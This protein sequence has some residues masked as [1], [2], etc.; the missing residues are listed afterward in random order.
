MDAFSTSASRPGWSKA[1]QKKADSHLRRKEPA[2]TLPVLARRRSGQQ[3]ATGARSSPLHAFLAEAND[4]ESYSRSQLRAM[5][6]SKLQFTG[7]NN[8]ASSNP[9]MHSNAERL[10]PLDP[11]SFEKTR[12]P[13]R[14]LPGPLQAAIDEVLAVRDTD[15]VLSERGESRD[16]SALDEPEIPVVPSCKRA[17]P[18]KNQFRSRRPEWR[19]YIRRIMMTKGIRGSTLARY[20]RLVGIVARKNLTQSYAGAA[21]RVVRYR[22]EFRSAVTIQIMISRFLMRRRAAKQM[23]RHRAASRIQHIW[24]KV[25]EIEKQRKLA[26]MA[27][28]A[29]I[30][31]LARLGAARTM[32]RS[33]RKYRQTCRLREKQLRE[34]QQA[35]MLQ[36]ARLKLFQRY[37]SWRASSKQSTI[38]LKSLELSSL[39]NAI[40]NASDRANKSFSS[41]ESSPISS[42]AHVQVAVTCA[43][44]VGGE[45]A[46][47]DSSQTRAKTPQNEPDPAEKDSTTSKLTLKDNEE[48]SDEEESVRL[49]EHAV[50]PQQNQSPAKLECNSASIIADENQPVAESE[51][52][53]VQD[54][55]DFS[56]PGSLECEEIEKVSSE[57]VISSSQ[58]QSVPESDHESCDNNLEHEAETSVASVDHN[59]LESFVENAASLIKEE[60][61]S[62]LAAVIENTRTAT[63]KRIARFLLPKVQAKHAEKTLA[64]IQIQCFARVCLAKQY[65]T[66]VRLAALQSL[67][68]QLLAAWCPAVP[69]KTCSQEDSRDPAQDEHDD[70]DN[71]FDLETQGYHPS[72][73][74]ASNNYLHLLPTRNGQ[75]PPGVPVLQSSAGAPLLSLWK[76]SWPGERW[77]STGQ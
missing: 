40:T 18:C 28:Q 51:G 15:E 36:R 52:A 22:L 2:V 1:L 32:Q 66:Q 44:N 33:Y 72:L 6:S 7:N 3:T 34:Q 19:R 46:T 71:E 47:A 21:E 73:H 59:D 24:R 53:L 29:E 45:L 13:R 25:F 64:A 20:R 56:S 42:R 8:L 12:A 11:S 61:A 30:E 62:E 43:P 67:R 60:R 57:V 37:Q 50:Q 76:W 39:P 54:S 5:A 35:T 49:N 14:P 38:D 75:I 41:Q 16:D 69:N 70:E 74:S 77:L 26:D 9:R 27:R 48:D 68:A 58:A 65:M 63:A 23:Q 17:S 55:H 4:R 10:A 31:R